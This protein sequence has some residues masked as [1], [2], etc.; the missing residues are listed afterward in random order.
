MPERAEERAL[1]I[2]D[3]DCAFCRHWVEAWRAETGDR[4]IYAPS[5]E[6]A[7]KFPEIPKTKYRRSI[8]LIDVDGRRYEGAQAAFRTLAHAPGKGWLNRLYEA[9]L[10]APVAEWAYRLVA[11]RRGFF[12]RATKLLWGARPARPRH[13][14]TAWIFLRALA[15]V[16]LFAFLSWL[17]QLPGLIGPGGI[18]PA[19]P[20]A[21]VFQFAALLGAAAAVSAFAG[22]LAGPMLFAAWVLY[23]IIANAAGDFA[24]FQWDG[25]LLEAGFLAIFLAPYRRARVEDHRVAASP[26]VIWLY[27]FLLFRLMFSSGLAKILHS[28]PSWK[29]LTAVGRHLET[30]PLPSPL[31]WHAHQLPAG[32]LKAASFGTL[33]MELAVPFLFLLPR[34]ARFVGAAL[35]AVYQIL[36]I[37]TGSFAF[38][39]WLALALCIMLLD[40]GAFERLFPALKSGKR[41]EHVRSRGVATAAAAL[42]VLI[43]L[44]QMAAPFPPGWR[45][46]AALASAAERLRLVNAYSMFAT[47]E[48]IREEVVIEGSADGVEWRAYEFLHKPGDV[49]R[50]PRF[51]SPFQPRLDWHMWFAAV[52]PPEANPWFGRLMVRLLQGSGDVLALLREN[53]FPDGPPKYVRATLYRYRFTTPEERKLDGA[54]WRSAMKV[55]YFPQMS[56]S[57][58][59]GG[60]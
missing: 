17:P 46:A 4:V 25:L 45:P 10:A 58:L 34:R 55:E 27:R 53:P 26:I 52:A 12:L 8:Q 59:P 51:A 16:Y 28:D 47:I 32:I 7:R 15:L 35:T 3:G 18:L 40:D 57:S 38:F 41:H 50:A 42:V 48:P 36:I 60:P 49:K 31:A 14:L 30:Q 11:R 20:N 2:Y 56:L 9:P 6:I 13:G 33:V 44:T 37:A 23:Y 43:G 5:Q 21:A 54:W 19:G 1:L 22:F 29:D 24:A 39:N